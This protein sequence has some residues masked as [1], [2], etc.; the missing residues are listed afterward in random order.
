MKW[1]I[2]IGKTIINANFKYITSFDELT[3]SVNWADIEIVRCEI[4]WESRSEVAEWIGTCESTVYCWNGTTGLGLSDKETLRNISPSN[5][6]C[7]MFFT[8][9]NDL[10]IFL[11]KYTARFSLKYFGNGISKVW[12]DARKI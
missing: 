9:I 4:D 2:R 7:Y 6:R 5:T 3:W 1:Y 12:T 11:L 8:N 10:E